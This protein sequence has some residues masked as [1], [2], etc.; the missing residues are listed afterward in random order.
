MGHKT[1]ETDALG[2]ETT[3][4]YTVDGKLEQTILPNGAVTQNVY[5]IARDIAYGAEIL[6][7]IDAMGE[8]EH[9]DYNACGKKI[10]KIDR[11]GNRTTYEYDPK[12]RLVKTIDPLG[13]ALSVEYDGNGN[14][15]A[16]KDQRGFTT[17]Y[18]YD[19][20]NRL[21]KEVIPCDTEDAACSITKTYEYYGDGKKKKETIQVTE[22]D[23]EDIAT[24]YE[25]DALGNL[26]GQTDGYGSATP[27]VTLFRHDALGNLVK[28]VQPLGNYKEIQYD[29]MGNQ[30]FVR[31]YD[32]N[33]VL[34][35]ETGNQYDGR[36]LLVTTTDPKG[37][38]TTFA[39]DDLGR[40]IERTDAEDNT[41]QFVYDEV[42]NITQII[43][44]L[45]RLTQT[46]YDLNNRKVKTVTAVGDTTS[47]IYDPNGNQTAVIQPDQ[48]RIRF[49]YDALN[50]KIGQQNELG[51]QELFEYDPTG[52]V[53]AHTDAMGN[54][55]RYEYDAA[56]RL[57]QTI[58]AKE[59]YTSTTYDEAGRKLSD[60]NA[61]GVVTQM[62]YDV[63]G[64]LLKQTMAAGTDDES[65]TRFEYDDNNQKI[66]EIR[67]LKLDGGGTRDLVTEYQYDDRGLLQFRIDGQHLG[68]DAE[69]SEYRYNEKRELYETVDPEGNVT[70]FAYDKTGNKIK[71]TVTTAQNGLEEYTWE[72]DEAGNIILETLPEGETIVRGYDDMD[73][74]NFVLKGSD[75]RHMDYNSRGWLI[76]EVNFNNEITEYDYDDA[77]RMLSKTAAKGTAD[78]A[79]TTYT[80][81][82]NG[83]TLTI[84]N[85]RGKMISYDYNELNQKVR[86]TD[87]DNTF[88]IFTWYAGGELKS[89]E[90]QDGSVVT[91]IRDNLDRTTEVRV[92][93]SLRQTFGYD[94][95]SR[96]ILATDNNEGRT[97]HT[98]TF[99]YNDLSRAESETQ[100][101]YTL[102]RQFD[103]NGNKT[104]VTYPSSRVVDKTYD[105]NNKLLKVYYQG[106]LAAEAVY[107][108]NRRLSSA[109]CGNGT[110]LS[111]GYEAD[112][113]RESTREYGS[114][115]VGSISTFNYAYDGQSNIKDITGI[116][117]TGNIDEAFE[118]D[119]LDRLASHTR[120]SS[121]AVTWEYDK[122]GNWERTNQN[123]AYE[124]RTVTD[125]NEYNL[126]DTL[127]PVHDDRGNMT[128]DGAQSY[129][130]DWASRLIK[131]ISGAQT[132]AGYTY[133]A[134]NRRVTKT[135]A[136]TTTTYVY[137]DGDVVEEYAGTTL[138][139][140]FVYGSDVD[141]PILMEYNGQTYYY[142]RDT[143]GS[144]RVITDSTGLP[145]ESYE[146]GPFGLMT[147]YNSLGQDI[148]A[149]G[150][151]IGNPY[152][153]TGRRWD[154]ES[155]LWYYR[156]RMYS[157]E[158]G[159]FLQRDPAGYVDGLNLYAYVLNNPLRFTDPD[160]LMAKAAYDY[161][162][163]DVS[164]WYDN[165]FSSVIYEDTP[166]RKYLPV[167]TNNN[168]LPLLSAAIQ[169]NLLAPAWNTAASSLNTL[170]HVQSGVPVSEWELLE[171]AAIMAPLSS[172]VTTGAK[173]IGSKIT[174]WVG[175]KFRS[176]TGVGTTSTSGSVWSKAAT[177]RGIDIENTLAKTDYKDWFNIGKKNNGYFPLVD[178]QKG[179]NLVSLKTVDTT[180]KT[181]LKRMQDHIDDLGTRGATVDGQQANMIL[182]LRVQ[183]GG[184]STAQSLI[185]YGRENNVTV[186]LKEFN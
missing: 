28:T 65:V 175:S 147:I 108:K 181:W 69:T 2:Q 84:T 75:Q 59:N 137:D 73:R 169:N 114:G 86:K 53:V 176:L 129:E 159:R 109:T 20:G 102:S 67:E 168:D 122:I 40:E 134:L 10:S 56:G 179:D 113:G 136:T 185:Q 78:Q 15:T 8:S 45:G 76:Q 48:S 72:Y 38:I 173:Y 25:Y 180:G 121:P 95:L 163:T 125:D 23:H 71:K 158:I 104:Q 93:N 44:G 130:Y 99:D 146:Y 100:D 34:L 51:A 144:I 41:F 31:F 22:P 79:T 21:I 156:N 184:S 35:E 151:T 1:K 29:A 14:V 107:D 66:F 54:I 133:D 92:D 49:F 160:G 90:R 145:A 103:G 77:G 17:T 81:D 68:T 5:D 124:T 87:S 126:I 149:T 6:S 118:Y 13:N 89:V 115:S 172:T 140:A 3:Y 70:T 111:I 85:A 26:S 142:S 55:T 91:Y 74:P 128:F 141:D 105:E 52:N 123:G 165:S 47:Y 37:Y 170:N 127:V 132:L 97:T 83:N 61:L 183:P 11:N 182:D 43:D 101:S 42:G 7:K 98:T 106:N 60:T 88:R 16:K 24:F 186:I 36:S 131:V 64:N 135:S 32:R 120:G 57:V 154:S 9:Y 12:G 94:S 171:T 174:S 117:N 167:M 33:G 46:F 155:G 178:F 161:V 30:L 82:D 152:G 39:Y 4:T 110:Y 139:R 27:L 96:M 150:S 143:L 19:A 162:S 138:A 153:F 18:E 116:F 119:H 177:Q 63:R 50:L 166:D 58:D 80:Y 164:N 148:T 157:A 112:R 62:Q